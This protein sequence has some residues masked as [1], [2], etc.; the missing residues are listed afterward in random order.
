MN[1]VLEGDG[2]S[3]ATVF[4]LKDRPRSEQVKTVPQHVQDLIDARLNLAKSLKVDN[5][6]SNTPTNASQVSARIQLLHSLELAG[7]AT[8]SPSV[9]EPLLRERSLS[10]HPVAV[11]HWFDYDQLLFIIVDPMHQFKSLRNQLYA[12]RCRYVL[13]VAS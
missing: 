3:F 5:P 11:R 2:I 7:I 12:K 9:I 6:R 8:P 13:M 10:D 4:F 1:Q